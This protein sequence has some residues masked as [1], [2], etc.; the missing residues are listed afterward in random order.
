[1]IGLA[2]DLRRVLAG[3]PGGLPCCE[4][5]RRVRRRRGD[6]L[7]ELRSGPCFEHAGHG[8]GSRWRLAGETPA[9]GLRAHL[10]PQDRWWGDLDASG[11][12]A[13]ARAAENG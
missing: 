12:P 9:T 3:E 2:G 13:L 8:R 11:V 10:G 1:V 6:V 5:V 7:A 4:L